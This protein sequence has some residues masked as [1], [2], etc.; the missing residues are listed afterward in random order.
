[1]RT[2]PIFV[3]T[4]TLCG[5]FLSI[6]KADSSPWRLIS[7]RQGI[8]TLRGVVAK[9]MQNIRRLFGKSSENVALVECRHRLHHENAIKRTK[10]RRWCGCTL[11]D[12]AND[13]LPSKHDCLAGCITKKNNVFPI[14][15]LKNPLALLQ[16]KW[17]YGWLQLSIKLIQKKNNVLR[18]IFL[19]S[20]PSH[21]MQPTEQWRVDGRGT[22]RSFKM[23]DVVGGLATVVR[24]QIK[25]TPGRWRR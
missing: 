7:E 1:M 4:R 25:Q 22:P 10:R 18:E 21:D 15:L 13:R 12:V 14:V 3:S 8:R 24:M 20:Y 2:I 9:I 11:P 23:P 6:P 17:N 19:R 16:K 5:W